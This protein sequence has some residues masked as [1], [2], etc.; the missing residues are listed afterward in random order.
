LSASLLALAVFSV[1][2]GAGAGLADAVV[3]ATRGGAPG[4]AGLFVGA[5]SLGALVALAAAS[6]FVL[7]APLVRPRDDAHRLSWVAAW[8]ALAPA[9]LSVGKVLY[10]RLP[11]NAGEG[12]MAAAALVGLVGVALG[13]ARL[14]GRILRRRAPGL[15]RGLVRLAIPAAL[16]L[17]PAGVR[18]AG[19]LRAP[20]ASRVGIPDGTNLLLLSVD[21]LRADA[22]GVMGDPRARTPCLDRIARRSVVASSCVAPSPWTLPSLGSLLTG[23]Y[24][25]EHRV[26]EHLSRLSE[27]VPTIAEVCARAGRRTAAFASNPW[28]G[29]G[30]LERGFDEWDVAE[31]LESLDATAPTRIYTAL[32]KIVLRVLRIDRA[33][34][35]N[36]RALSWLERGEGAWFLWIHYFDPHLPNWPE[37][38]WD[39]LFGPPPHRID[40]SL[41]ANEIRDDAWPGGASERGEVARLY[42]G[43]VAYTDHEI[44]R[45]WRRLAERGDLDRTA[46]VFTAD[47]G[48]ELWD[49][50]DY[51]H[52]HSMFGEVVR[53]PLFLKRPGETRGAILPT[54][55]RLVDLAPTSLALADIDGGVASFTGEN[56]LGGAPGPAATFGEALLYGDELKYLQTERWKLI[57]RPPA[58]GVAAWTR[59]FDLVHDPAEQI[60]LAPAD[61]ALTDTLSAYLAHWLEAVGIGGTGALPDP[62]GLDPAL[63]QQLKAL[64]YLE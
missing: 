9:T 27:T 44:G 34:A 37:R 1:L 21:T 20:S 11:W 43:E 6:P 2:V 29:T 7:S 5:T 23:S 15:V 14:A 4:T 45:L 57:H 17:L 55:A 19:A 39:R 64:G 31:R 50:G 61:P 25:G 54:L 53:V 56:L 52:G 58:N 28:L 46:V 38:P 49:H 59:L 3:A 13:L 24:P 8:L 16:L 35:L 51:G 47:H 62:A 26:L 32:S 10:H 48:E 36:D 30:A 42:F 33:S 12:A 63:R 22:L 41:S 40:S 18:I 60:D